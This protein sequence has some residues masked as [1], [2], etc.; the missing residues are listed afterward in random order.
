[1]PNDLGKLAESIADS[2]KRAV[3][4][5]SFTA[6]SGSKIYGHHLAIPNGVLIHHGHLKSSEIH[7]STMTFSCHMV[8]LDTFK[9]RNVSHRLST[10]WGSLDVAGV[11]GHG[12]C[13]NGTYGRICVVPKLW[14]SWISN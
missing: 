1:M 6:I 3:R 8:K 4:F 14:I 13:T 7:Q 10:A 11:A 5:E 9:L 2:K 12:L